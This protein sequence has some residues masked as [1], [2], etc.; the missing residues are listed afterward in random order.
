MAKGSRRRTPALPRAAAV[1]SEPVEDPMNPARL[2]TPILLPLAFLSASVP[3][4]AQNQLRAAQGATSLNT[5]SQTET[6]SLLYAMPATD[7]YD[8]LL[9][10]I[11]TDPLP[12]ESFEHLGGEAEI[13]ASVLRAALSGRESGI[14]ILLY[15]PP[16]TGKTSF[17]ATL[18][19]RIGARLRPVTEADEEGGE[20]SRSE[21]L[22]GLRLAQS[23]A[24]PEKTLLLFDEAEDLFVSRGGGFD[25]SAANSRVFMHR[26]LE[27]MATPVIWMTPLFWA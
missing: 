7:F 3:A 16:G 1:V 20:P 25:A 11:A 18:A 14:N 10:S 2:F 17:A 21:R 24:A 8:Q 5:S 22:A 6:H 15:G 19:E 27:R 13:A 12:W 9:G 4:P 26:L 23:L